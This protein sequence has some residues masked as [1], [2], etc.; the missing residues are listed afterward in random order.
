M[1]LPKLK[2]NKKQS[3][4]VLKGQRPIVA[5]IILYC[6][7]RF[8]LWSIMRSTIYTTIHLHIQFLS[9]LLKAFFVFLNKLSLLFLYYVSSRPSI[10]MSQKHETEHIVLPSTIS[11]SAADTSQNASAAQREFRFTPNIKHSLSV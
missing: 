3:S 7:L 9:F 6:T 10:L 2:V 4:N 11:L 1:I 5:E 8:L